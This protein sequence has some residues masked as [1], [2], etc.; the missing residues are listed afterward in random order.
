[1]KKYRKRP[2]VIEAAVF[3]NDASSYHLLHWINEGQHKNNKEFAQWHND[4]LIIPT[5]EG[6]HTANVGDYIIKGV[7]GEFYP[8]K[9]D[10]FEKTYEAVP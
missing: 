10:V 2:V 5:L 6:D 8:C 9:P 1:M 7:V 4:K 3:H